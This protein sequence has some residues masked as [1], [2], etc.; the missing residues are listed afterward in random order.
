VRG[1]LGHRRQ[2]ER[3]ILRLLETGHWRFRR[4]SNRCTRA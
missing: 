4:W 3:Q 1:M 2:R